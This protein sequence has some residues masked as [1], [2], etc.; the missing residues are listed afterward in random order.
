MR[1]GVARGTTLGWYERY[2]LLMFR[3]RIGPRWVW[4]TDEGLIHARG[5]ARCKARERHCD[6][7]AE[8]FARGEKVIDS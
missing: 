4:Q 6:M 8:R 1:L 7:R 3:R 2:A 5:V